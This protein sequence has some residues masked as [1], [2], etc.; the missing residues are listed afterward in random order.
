MWWLYEG[1]DPPVP[2]PYHSAWPMLCLQM[3]IKLELI[4]LIRVNESFIVLYNYKNEKTWDINLI[5]EKYI[6]IYVIM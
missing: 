4:K 1:S 6:Y 2:S 3:L 5:W